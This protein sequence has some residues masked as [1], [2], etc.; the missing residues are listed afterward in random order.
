MICFFNGQD[1]QPIQP[2]LPHA[3]QVG[4]NQFQFGKESLG[5]C[6]VTCNVRNNSRA[7]H[8]RWMLRS[9]LWPVYFPNTIAKV[10]NSTVKSNT[11][12][13]KY[14]YTPNGV[15]VC[16]RVL[17]AHNSFSREGG[18]WRVKRGGGSW[19]VHG[20]FMLSH[21]VVFAYPYGS[22]SALTLQSFSLHSRSFSQSSPISMTRHFSTGGC[23]ILFHELHN[24]FSQQCHFLYVLF[25]KSY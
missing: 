10:S 24:P 5:C 9:K 15:C 21:V 12:L 17:Q 2:L 1:S 7:V 16:V 23:L 6:P 19:W 18:S 25:L 8:R 14:I 3:A 11:L 22:A 13:V 4:L 20:G